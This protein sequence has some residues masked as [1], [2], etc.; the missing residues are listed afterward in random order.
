VNFISEVR[1][2][3]INHLEQIYALF[4]FGIV[5]MACSCRYM[6][7]SYFSIDILGYMLSLSLSHAWI[8]VTFLW[9]VSV[10]LR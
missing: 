3:K 9:F 4:F 10:P 8:I 6:H 2:L 1:L 7:N 5:N